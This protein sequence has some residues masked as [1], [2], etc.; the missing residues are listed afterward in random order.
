M[1]LIAHPPR[2]L[3][4]VFDWDNTLVD[5]WGVIHDALNTTL[6]AFDKAPWS[7]DETRS[8]VRKSTRDSFPGLFGDKW[9]AAM[10][11]FYRR[12]AEIHKIKLEASAGAA[13][14]LETL[15]SRDFYMAI[16]SNKR[17]DYLRAEVEHLGWDR[18]FKRTIGATDAARDKPAPDPIILALSEA[19][20]EPG[21]NVWF[22]G[23]ADIDLNCAHQAGCYPVLLRETP[24]GDH[25]FAD[26]PPASHFTDCM[27]LCK[28]VDNL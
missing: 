28:F 15:H 6:I 1:E 7:L 4:L 20:I 26:S 27:A 23:D 8:K 24:P 12:Y 14:M 19:E 16:V 17:G 25:E 3:A 5:T 11:L 22:I 2:P 21:K 13:E 10:E 9:E 18:F